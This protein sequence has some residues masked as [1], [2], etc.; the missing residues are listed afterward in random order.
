[1]S[2]KLCEECGEVI[3]V[4]RLEVLPDTTTCVKHSLVK[5]NVVMSVYSHKTAPETVIIDAEDRESVRLADRANR[6]AR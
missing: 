5:K 4:E 3:P 6:R 2:E 1:M